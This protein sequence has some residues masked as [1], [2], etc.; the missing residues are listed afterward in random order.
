[1]ALETPMNRNASYASSSR[2]NRPGTLDYLVVL[3]CLMFIPSGVA[4]GILDMG[5]RTAFALFVPLILVASL[6]ANRLKVHKIILPVALVLALTG[7]LASSLS[8]SLSQVLMAFTLVVAVVVGRQLYATLCK[9][10]VL[11]AVSLFAFALLVGGVIGIAYSAVGG[12]PLMEVQVSYRTTYLYLTTFSFA[13][14]GSIIRPSGIFDEPG[15]FVMYV[16]LI[17]MF[18]DTLRQNQKLNTVMVV[19]LVFTGSLAGVALAALYALTSN[20]A[21]AHRNKSFL[22]LGSLLAAFMALTAIVPSNLVSLTVDTFYSSRLQ[23]EDGRLSGDNRS[24]QVSE[25]F[26]IVDDDIL[27]RGT[28]NATQLDE[29]E[30]QTSNPFSIVY[31]YGLLISLPYFVLL[32]WLAGTA[33]RQNFRNSYSSLGLLLL[34]LQRPYLYNM[35][36]SIL[37]LAAVW[38]VYETSR[39]GRNGSGPAQ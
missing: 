36:W 25:F 27:L 28:H 26:A 38:L 17:T 24:T 30:D 23:V 19:L 20:G 21:K 9:P 1:M 3:I 29:A 7:T 5:E 11:R 39:S 13:T 15:S 32:L 35:A 6:I 34:L 2:S 33:I 4:R 18:N 12:S 8:Q 37:I 16:S 31:G 10:R 14:I 22:I